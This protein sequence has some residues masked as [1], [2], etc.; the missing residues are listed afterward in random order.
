MLNSKSTII[1]LILLIVLTASISHGAGDTIRFNPEEPKMKDIKTVGNMLDSYITNNDKANIKSILAY[2]QDRASKYALLVMIEFHQ[3]LSMDK[4]QMMK[5]KSPQRW[6]KFQSYMN[7]A[8]TW[9]S[10]SRKAENF[11]GSNLEKTLKK[12][13]GES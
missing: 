12:E 1:T 11:L 6:E 4:L 8:L 7:K 9:L 3:D 10:L 5:Q 13:L 2:T